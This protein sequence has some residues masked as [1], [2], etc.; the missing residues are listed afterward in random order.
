M[1]L[2]KRFV[3]RYDYAYDRLVKAIVIE[4]KLE[5]YAAIDAINEE[6]LAKFDEKVFI[7]DLDGVKVLDNEAKELYMHS[8]Q[9]SLDEILNNEVRR[10]ISVDKVRP[11]GRKLDEIRPLSSRVD[12]LP[13]ARFIYP[14]SN[15]KLR[16][17][18]S[19]ISR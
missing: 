1:K 6:T 18:N 17:Y 9:Y 8:V 12:V 14:W 19:W 7:K 5:R 3:N 11:D 13:R 2:T 15:S 10:L 4:D 16:C